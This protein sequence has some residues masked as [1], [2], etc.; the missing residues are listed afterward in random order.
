MT[1]REVM[2]NCS[3]GNLKS[4]TLNLQH[5]RDKYKQALDEIKKFINNQLDNFGNDVYSMDKSAINNIQDII[6]KVKGVK[7]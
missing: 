7:K 1:D 5:E 6:N 3:N 4:Y 2:I